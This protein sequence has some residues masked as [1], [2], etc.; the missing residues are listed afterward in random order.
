MD[1]DTT[2][3][4]FQISSNVVC[5]SLTERIITRPS[6]GQNHKKLLA[7]CSS[8]QMV[9]L[10]FLFI[11]HIVFIFFES[12]RHPCEFIELFQVL[13]LFIVYSLTCYPGEYLTNRLAILPDVS[14]V[15]QG[16]HGNHLFSFSWFHGSLNLCVHPIYLIF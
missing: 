10:L 2:T 15:Q 14:K 8:I 4:S 9:H 7:C 6:H 5:E 13:P 12:I 16:Q 3:I 11:W 1:K